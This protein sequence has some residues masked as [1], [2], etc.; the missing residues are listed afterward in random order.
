MAHL[1]LRAICIVS[2]ASIVHLAAVCGSGTTTGLMEH[3]VGIACEHIVSGAAPAISIFRIHVE[4]DPVLVEAS[5]SAVL[6]VQQQLNI[7]RRR[8]RPHK[9]WIL[10][11]AAHAVL[12]PRA[13]GRRVEPDDLIL[14]RQPKAFQLF[15]QLVR[16]VRI[17]L[18]L[19]QEALRVALPRRPEAPRGLAERIE[20]SQLGERA[21]VASEEL[22][23]ARACLQMLVH[24]GH[25]RWVRLHHPI[26]RLRQQ[27]T[28]NGFRCR[29]RT[30][31]GGASSRRCIIGRTTRYVDGG[32]V[33]SAG[34]IPVVVDPAIRLE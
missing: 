9:V 30:A 25:Q 12:V 8:H 2:G 31:C 22:L 5:K 28:H 13:I 20:A 26:V 15:A 24:L 4:H 17:L 32:G 33:V 7:R 23:Q 1:Q 3:G 18:R 10:P 29:W 6:A 19:A 11:S 14:V 21:V 27:H 34:A 16:L